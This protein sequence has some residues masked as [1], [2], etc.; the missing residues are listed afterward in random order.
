MVHY[1]A[2]CDLLGIR[3]GEIPQ[4]EMDLTLVRYPRRN[5]KQ[6]FTVCLERQAE[7]KPKCHIAAHMGLG[8]AGRVQKTKF[9]E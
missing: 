6:A 1:G 7:L 9:S 2:G 4:Q 3:Y 5:F 8:M